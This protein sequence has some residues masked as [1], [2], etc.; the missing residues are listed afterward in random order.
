MALARTLRR[1]VLAAVV[2]GGGGFVAMNSGVVKAFYEDIYPSDP[3]KRQA[4]EFCFMHDHKFNRLDPD[5]RDACYRTML[6]P[7]GELAGQPPADQPIVNSVDL[8][9]AAGMGSVPR[10]DVRRSE[11]TRALR[12][13]H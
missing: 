1:L 12:V 10:T 13:P 11:E 5:Q 9:R 2:V 4:L 3:A 6:M 7:R 8:Q